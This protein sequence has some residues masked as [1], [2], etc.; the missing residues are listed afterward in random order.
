MIAYVSGKLEEVYSDRIV[1][2]SNGIGYEILTYDYVIRKLP[3]LHSDI[4]IVTYMEVKED[5][6]RLFGFLTNQERKL[7]TQLISVSGVGPKG[8][9]AILDELG[10]DN[11]CA[12]I[13]ASDYK[14][15]SKANGVGT[16]TA[17]KVVLDLK[18]KLDLEG[19]IFDQSSVDVFDNDSSSDISDAAQALCE[20]G[21]S[22]TDALKAI[23]KVE[24]ADKMKTEDIIRAALKN[25]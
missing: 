23:R 15:I 18:D 8:A 16:K 21:Y 9:L 5:D 13:I 20:L 24:G 4:K 7:F 25:L 10:P 19:T 14:A 11:L 12:A 2:D 22:N 6:I 1:V 3:A 17:Q